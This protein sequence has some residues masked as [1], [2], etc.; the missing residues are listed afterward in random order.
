MESFVRT[1][2]E[3]MVYVLGAY[4]EF[5]PTDDLVQGRR[6]SWNIVG[7]S[8]VQLGLI[9]GGISMALG[10]LVFRQRQVAIYSGGQ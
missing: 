6:V 3:S 2:A 7:A 5:Q 8:M 10:W 4:G 1:I 9:W